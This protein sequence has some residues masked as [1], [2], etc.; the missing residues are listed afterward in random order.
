MLL[1]LHLIAALLSGLTFFL[2]GFGF[3]K[4][5]PWYQHKGLLIST[6]VINTVLL[7]T[8]FA[9]VFGQEAHYNLTDGWILLKLIL[10]V[11]Y[12]ALGIVAFKKFGSAETKKQFTQFWLIGLALFVYIFLV[13]KTHSVTLGLF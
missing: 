7:V 11:V 12:I 8:A 5:K 4:D 13:G 1:K 3:I 6:H 9:L 2:R 10:L